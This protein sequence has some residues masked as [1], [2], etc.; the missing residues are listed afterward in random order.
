MILTVKSNFKNVVSNSIKITFKIGRIKVKLNKKTPFYKI[1]LCEGKNY[2]WTASINKNWQLSS[3]SGNI[4]TTKKDQS[5]TL[6]L[7]AIDPT[8]PLTS[9]P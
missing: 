4:K 9:M 2:A 5:I 7:I 3:K 6:S 8:Y 1:A